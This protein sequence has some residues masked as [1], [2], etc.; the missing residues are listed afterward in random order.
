M[1]KSLL[2]LAVFVSL[3]T[4][5]SC[6]N[7]D[8]V[9]AENQLPEPARTYVQKNYPDDAILYVKED[10]ELFSKTYKVQLATGLELEFDEDGEIIDID[11]DD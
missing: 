5:T 7:E 1:K 9:I 10:N 3:L 8:K 4:L 11:L 6:W 2:I